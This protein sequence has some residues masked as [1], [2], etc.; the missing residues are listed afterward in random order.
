MNK[1]PSLET[2]KNLLISYSQNKITRFLS[3]YLTAFQWLS[4]VRHSRHNAQCG[5]KDPEA[6]CPRAGVTL[7]GL[8]IDTLTPAALPGQG[9]GGVTFYEWAEDSEP[10]RLN[11]KLVGNF[12]LGS[13]TVNKSWQAAAFSMFFF[14]STLIWACQVA[15]VVKNPP[16]NAGDMRDSGSMPGL[17]RSHMTSSN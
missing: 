8:L 4:L 12:L 13:L 10:E 11:K 3:F 17:G 14:S 7:K 9:S 15:L 16:A 6:K 1:Q 5:S 2:T